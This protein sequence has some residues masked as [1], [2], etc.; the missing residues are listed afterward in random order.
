MPPRRVRDWPL[1]DHAH[2][3]RSGLR[4]HAID[5]FL[6]RDTHRN[7]QRVE[8]AALDRVHRLI[9]VGAASDEARLSALA[10][11]VDHLDHPPVFERRHRR[12]MELHH[13]DVIGPE[14]L[15]TALDTPREHG[16]FPIVIRE[17]RSARRSCLEPRMPALGHQHNFAAPR[18]NRLAHQRLAVGITLGGIDHIDP[19]IER[20]VQNFIDGFLRDSL[21]ADFRPPKPKRRNPQPG[22]AQQSIF[23]SHKGAK[24]I[25]NAPPKQKKRPDVETSGLCENPSCEIVQAACLVSIARLSSAIDP[26]LENVTAIASAISDITTIATRRGVTPPSATVVNGAAR[27]ATRF[28]T[29]IIGLSA[30]PAVSLN[31]SPTVSPTTDALCTSVPLPPRNPSSTFFLALSQLAPAFDMNTAINWP[32]RIVPP[33]KPPSAPAPRPKPTSSGEKIARIPG[34]SSSFCDAAVTISTHAL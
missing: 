28:I 15:E 10:R 8:R 30:G 27:I 19:R 26:R 21:V 4:Q 17:T 29:L 20:G 6:V 13:I 1:D 34:P 9:G 23:D 14:I 25:A 11:F 12:A 16:R 2:P 31:G 33:R 7:L 3:A 22:L 5:C 32:V 24:I 18:A